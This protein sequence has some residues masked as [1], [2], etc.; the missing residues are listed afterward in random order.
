[1]SVSDFRPTLLNNMLLKS[2]VV[3]V[4]LFCVL[5]LFCVVFYVLFFCRWVTRSKEKV[6]MHSLN[7][8]TT[9]SLSHNYMSQSFFKIILKLYYRCQFHFQRIF[10]ETFGDMG[11]KILAVCSLDCQIPIFFLFCN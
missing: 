4:C 1:M 6:S 8:V 7:G 2:V 11:T 3:A 10:T 9:Y 5:M